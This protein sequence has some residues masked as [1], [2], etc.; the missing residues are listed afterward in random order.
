MSF[1]VDNQHAKDRATQ[2]A[3]EM[4]SGINETTKKEINGLLNQAFNNQLNKKELLEKLQTS[5]AF[6]KYRANMIA[7]NEVGT[8]YIQG[9]VKQHQELMKRT[10]I[11]GRKYWQTSND[12]KVSDICMD[13]QNQDWI[14]FNQDFFSGHFCPLGHVNCRCKLRVRPFKP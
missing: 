9:T 10:G 14:P 7:N 2:H 11:E 3:G 6:S 5:F 4:I 13:N 12:D 1:A 8:A